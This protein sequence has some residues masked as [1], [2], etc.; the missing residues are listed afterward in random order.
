MVFDRS[1]IT[2]EKVR[3]HDLKDLEKIF[4]KEFS[5]EVSAEIIQQRVHR[6]RQFYYILFPLSRFSHWVN[7]LF[8][9]YIVRVS[10]SVAGFIQISYLTAQQ[11]HL[12]FIAISKKFRGQGLGTFVLKALF[13]QVVDKNHFDVLLEVRTDNP[14]RLLYERLGFISQAQVLHYE[15]TFEHDLQIDLGEPSANVNFE[16]VRDSDRAAL[17]RLYRASIPRRL[18]RVVKREFREFNPSLFIRNLT[19]LK[20]QLMRIETQEFIIRQDNRVVASMEIKSYPKAKV[21]ILSMIIHPKWESLRK[22]LV[23]EALNRLSRKYQQ[24]KVTT[25]IYDDAVVKQQVL[26]EMGFIKQESYYLMLRPTSHPPKRTL[27]PI[28]ELYF[29]LQGTTRREKRRF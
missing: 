28:K 3:Y 7:N 16:P 5:D 27:R 6:V 11:L 4:T 23:T 19:W 25:T 9:I 12:D 14:A 24:G 29:Q 17:Y 22:G 20:N 26:E 10:G 13:E 18:Q 2:I 15:R 8:N 21:H 1:A